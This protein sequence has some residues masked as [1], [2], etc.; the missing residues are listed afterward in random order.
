MASQPLPPAPAGS[1]WVGGRRNCAGCTLLSGWSR[2]VRQDCCCDPAKVVRDCQIAELR[3]AGGRGMGPGQR[4]AE[5]G[6]AFLGVVAERMGRGCYR[7][8]RCRCL[9]AE[10][11]A[12]SPLKPDVPFPATVVITPWETLRT[13][14]L[15]ESAMYGLPAESA[16]TQGDR[17]IGRW[18]PG[19][20]R[21]GTNR[22]RL[23]GQASR[24]GIQSQDLDSR[25]FGARSRLSAG[26]GRP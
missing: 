12:L 3:V 15:L 21:R 1:S 10:S 22:P 14:L 26:R 5:E 13:R 2:C 23:Q 17:S 24:S 7:S 16:A 19:C 18:W 25:A 20:C 11:T 8:P 9:P 4:L 6:G